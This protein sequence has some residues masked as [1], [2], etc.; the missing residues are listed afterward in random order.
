[1]LPSIIKPEINIKKLGIVSRDYRYKYANGCRDFSNTLP[2]I[3]DFL[4]KKKC[5]SVLFSLYT[6]T[7]GKWNEIYHSINSLTNITSLFIEEFIDGQ[8]RKVAR[9]VIIH[10]EAGIWNEYEIHQ[11]FATLTGMSE[12]EISNF[13]RFEMPKRII[14]NS[15]VLLCG[16][17]NGVKYSPSDK[18]VH[19]TYGLEKSIPSSVNIILNPVHDRM[20]RFEMN[21]K[22]KFLSKTNRWV[23]SVWNKGKQDKNGIV[24]DGN[25][26]AWTIYHN[27]DEIEIEAVMKQNNF[28]VGIL[29]IL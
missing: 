27:G 8:E 2:V 19:D 1:M 5:D 3:L 25:S 16:E 23:I 7:S 20:T 21:L 22:R 13:V 17:S 26:P 4:D 14:G 24:K 6:V 29:E 10:K 11:K 18:L 28:E 9:Y 12:N 15:V